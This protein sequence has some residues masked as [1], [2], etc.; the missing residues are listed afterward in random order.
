MLSVY[1]FLLMCVFKALKKY[2]RNFRDG[3]KQYFSDSRK[4]GSF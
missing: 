3:F 2:K 1:F 4:A